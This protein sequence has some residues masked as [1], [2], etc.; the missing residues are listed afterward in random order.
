MTWLSIKL[1]FRQL[2]RQKLFT[3]L[4]VLGLAIGIAGCFSIAR[5]IDYELKF[6]SNHKD[7]DQIYQ[8]MSHSRFEGVSNNFGGVPLPLSSYLEDQ[9][10]EIELAVPVYVRYFYNVNTEKNKEDFT[11]PTLLVSTN[12]SYFDL[13]AYKWLAGNKEN[14]LKS[15]N[16]VVLT[17]SRAAYYF[18]DADPQQVIGKV[19]VYNDSL[20]YT[21]TGVV[22]DL[23]YP[24]SFEGKEFFPIPEKELKST[25]WNARNSNHQL[26][27]KVNSENKKQRLLQAINKKLDEETRELKNKYKY[28]GWFE[29]LP[30]KDKHFTPSANNGAHSINRSVLYVLLSIAIFLIVLACINYINLTTAQLP[31]RAKQ[32]GIQKSL[33]ASSYKIMQIFFTETF[34]TLVCAI[35]IA[36]PFSLFFNHTFKD[37]I[38]T[39]IANFLSTGEIIGFVIV[40]IVVLTLINGVYPAWLST[41]V[42]TVKI[43]KSSL[44]EGRKKIWLRKVLIIFQFTISQLFVIC[45]IIIGQQLHYALNANLG[46]DHEAVII[47][48]IPHR[49][50]NK[51]VTNPRTYAKALKKHPEFASVALGHTPFSSSM[52]GNTYYRMVD[53]TKLQ[54]QINLKFIDESYLDLYKLKILAGS[55]FIDRS[56]SSR[57]IIINEKAVQSY[58]F[59]S[60]QQA[61]GQLLKDGS[62]KDIR[63]IGVVNDFNQFDFRST[64]GPIAFYYGKPD[65]LSNISIKLSSANKGEWESAIKVMEKEWK[66]SYPD[67]TFQYKF[68]EQ[69]IEDMYED[70]RRTAKL[71]NIS[72]TITLFISCLGLFG[73]ITLTSYQRTKEIGIRKI[74]GAKNKQLFILLTKDFIWLVLIAS[75][76]ATPIALYFMRKWLEDFSFRISISPWVFILA[77]IAG[78]LIAYITTSIQAIRAIRRNPANSL[79]DE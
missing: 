74:L 66:N 65:N 40:F 7:L 12:G 48:E 38:P 41:R 71:I 8:I 46:F 27:V 57:H 53:T 67:Q 33:G 19:L 45:T 62:D 30:L 20:L 76:I 21:V 52:W 11:S 6:D 63:I 24:S 78:I 43:L 37:I 50:S 61:V 77:S 5:I 2:W 75:V 44:G 22:R 15:P 49:L 1:A 29:L 42:N 51:D 32:I 73:L 18:K 68:Y 28:E 70:D 60:P 54:T 59:D 3:A 69:Q 31:K 79:R 34:V 10:S 26:F 39:E 13:V 58:G 47:Q 23:D 9:R 14:V 17:A 35:V 72:A 64:V 25:D 36:I 55:N 4:N 16:E 56:D